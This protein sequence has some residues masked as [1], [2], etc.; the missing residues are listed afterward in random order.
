M[1]F[2]DALALLHPKKN[3]FQNPLFGDKDR[4]IKRFWDSLGTGPAEILGIF[5]VHPRI[6]LFLGAGDGDGAFEDFGDASGMGNP[7]ILGILWG[8]IPEN[9]RISGQG[10]G[11]ES[12]GFSHH[13]SI[14]TP[15]A[16]N[17]KALGAS[18]LDFLP[19]PSKTS[20]GRGRHIF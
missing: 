1:A 18:D 9:L 15:S 5:G 20:K 14:G 8:K 4:A 2:I 12:R 7:Q 11:K 6:P 16:K 3:P 19:K 13:Y 10:W 17:L